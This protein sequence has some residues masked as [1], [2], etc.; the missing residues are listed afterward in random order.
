[1][2]TR[3][4][5]RGDKD[6]ITGFNFDI[7]LSQWDHRVMI[8][9]ERF[10]IGLLRPDGR[11]HGYHG[12]HMN[13]NV[14]TLLYVHGNAA[15]AYREETGCMTISDLTEAFVGG[16]LSY[17]AVR[18][19]LMN[20]TVTYAPDATMQALLSDAK[21]RTLIIEPGI[22]WREEELSK[23]SLMTNYSLLDPAST[24]PY[25]VP[26]DD[27]Y[28]RAYALLDAYDGFFGVAEAFRVLAAVRQEEPWKT[29]VSFV[30][31]ARENAVYYCVDSD[32][33]RVKKVVF[34]HE[35]C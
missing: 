28:A 16:V 2:C 34:G 27:R 5:F 32:F 11:R 14:G 10:Y 30:Y 26:G 35:C 9:P 3:F 13:G 31:S 19:L 8:E 15:G 1:M 22:G 21:G 24:A 33:T 29:R 17:D 12:V 20:T 4:V 6:V 23:F 25:I 7:D 18:T